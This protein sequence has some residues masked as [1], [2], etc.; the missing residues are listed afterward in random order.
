MSVNADQVRHVAKL[1]RLHLTD[2]IP[3]GKG[4]SD[5]PRTLVARSAQGLSASSATAF[6]EN[7]RDI[8]NS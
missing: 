8:W 7:A 2:F 1:A 3:G 4:T 5:C 6:L